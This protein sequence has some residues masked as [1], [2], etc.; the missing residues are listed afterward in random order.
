MAVPR[1]PIEFTIRPARTDTPAGAL[2]LTHG[3]GADADDL[4]PLLDLLDPDGRLVGI[5][6]RGPLKLPPS[7]R[8]W[9]IVREVG[10]PDADTFLPTYSELAE[11]LDETLAEHGVPWERT[12]LGGF[13]QGTVMSYAVGLGAGRPR[14]AAILAFSGFIPIVDGFEIDLAGRAG[15]PVSIAHG[16]YDPVIGVE[17]GRRAQELLEAAG[18]AVA[19]REDPVPHSIAPGAVAQAVTVLGDRLR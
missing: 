1:S 18:L 14:P 4:G 6:P 7:G 8:H 17:F 5:F 11:R 12:A 9:Y 10:F 13:S 16:T 2:V 19:Y 3:R 15:L